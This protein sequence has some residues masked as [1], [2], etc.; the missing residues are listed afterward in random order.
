EGADAI[1][2]DE[3]TKAAALPK[4]KR[5]F[6]LATGLP[7]IG[8]LELAPEVRLALASM[9]RGGPFPEDLIEA[10]AQGFLKYADL[11]AIGELAR[12]RAFPEPIDLPCPHGRGR[13][14]GGFRVAYAHDD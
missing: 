4:L 10:L 9:P 13:C 3:L 7:V 6:G 1:L 12:G 8:A 11:G 5:I 14:R 2:L